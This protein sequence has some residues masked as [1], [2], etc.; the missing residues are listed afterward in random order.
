M[1]YFGN[2][3]LLIVTL[4]V[5][6]PWTTVRSAR[7]HAASLSLHGPVALEQVLQPDKTTAPTG[8][9][10]ANFLENGFELS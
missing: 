5:A 1:L 9:G 4:G 7:F 2:L 6:W 3:A 8:E 10:L